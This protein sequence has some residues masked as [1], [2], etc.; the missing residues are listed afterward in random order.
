MN[1]GR[2]P[3][4][5]ESAQRT[6]AGLSGALGLSVRIPPNELKPDLWDVLP[7]AKTLPRKQLMSDH[8]T[9][10]G[11]DGLRDTCSNARCLHLYTPCS[12]G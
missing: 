10:Q 1:T 6:L 4:R 3:C 11:A 5:Q 7:V 2:L 9:P 12:L 8:P